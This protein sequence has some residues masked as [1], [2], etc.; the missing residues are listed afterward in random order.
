MT[1]RVRRKF[2]SHTFKV[3]NQVCKVFLEPWLEF[4]P[5]FWLWHVGF[6][7][8]KSKRQINDWYRNRRNK[9]RRSLHNKLTGTSGVTA[10]FRGF[11]TLLSLRWDIP[12][13]DAIVVDCTSGSPDQQFKAYVRWQQRHPDWLINYQEQK[14]FW[15]RPPYADD[16][17]REIARITECRP[18]DP[19]V[20]TL[21]ENYYN[22]FLVHLL[23]PYIDQSIQ[24]KD[25]QS[26]QAQ[27]SDTDLE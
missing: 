14:V 12:A 19:M 8:G 27:A 5:G 23:N 9:R 22:S 16:P 26:D 18:A 1:Y 4:S 17:I 10:F 20:N 13:G 25:H 6:C 2:T 21:G 15:Y 24:Q 7:V 3:N 11:K